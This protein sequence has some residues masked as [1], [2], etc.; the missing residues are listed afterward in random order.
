VVDERQL[1]FLML[2]SRSVSAKVEEQQPSVRLDR[3]HN[4]AEHQ[5]DNIFGSEKAGVVVNVSM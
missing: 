4:A 2:S 3:Y 1:T 5:L